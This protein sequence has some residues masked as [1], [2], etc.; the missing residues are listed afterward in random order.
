MLLPSTGGGSFGTYGKGAG[1][2]RTAAAA[3]A[4]IAITLL[5][6]A[7]RPFQPPGDKAALE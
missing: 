2:H 7:D 5:A 6:M 1:R 4:L 3:I